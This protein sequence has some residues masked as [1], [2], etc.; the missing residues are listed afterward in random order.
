[1]PTRVLRK[2]KKKYPYRIFPVDLPDRKIIKRMKPHRVWRFLEVQAL[3]RSK[4]I[5]ALYMQ[6]KR[7]GA[8]LLRQEF[9]FFWWYFTDPPSILPKGTEDR[10]PTDLLWD[11]AETGILEFTISSC[12]TP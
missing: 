4:K 7:K 10:D 9:L 5:Q 1:M 6:G 11:F 8:P 3:L 12:L 2:P